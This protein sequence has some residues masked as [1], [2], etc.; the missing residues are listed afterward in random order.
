MKSPASVHLKCVRVRAI[1][2]KTGE[3]FFWKVRKITT[4]TRV[5]HAPGL[6]SEEDQ[7]QLT[8]KAE[9]AKLP[10]VAKEE[11]EVDEDEKEE[12]EAEAV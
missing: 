8:K 11:G 4:K 5:E 12:G 1:N 7:E 6:M 9:A 10:K 3:R 2:R